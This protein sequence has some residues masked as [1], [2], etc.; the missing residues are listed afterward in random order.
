MSTLA[1]TPLPEQGAKR[2]KLGGSSLVRTTVT[3]ASS[4]LPA[5]VASDA[6]YPV[7]RAT[8]S[9]EN[10]ND[11]PSINPLVRL[12]KCREPFPLDFEEAVRN[13][14]VVEG[15]WLKLSKT[16]DAVTGEY[17]I[18]AWH[19]SMEALKFDAGAPDPL[20]DANGFEYIVLKEPVT[21]A[22]PDIYFA[23]AAVQ[24]KA[25][26][27]LTAEA[28]LSDGQIVFAN[29]LVMIIEYCTPDHS[30]KDAAKIKYV[31]TGAISQTIY[32]KP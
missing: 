30:Y 5:S 29:N 14:R 16:P 31:C 1:Y 13:R 21:P 7:V 19:E 25:T 10:L 15:T 11:D 18:Q 6:K 23:T 8:A 26:V 28:G 9:F 12:Y 2:A 24:D 4:L 27:N 32:Q 3:S 20:T 22:G 17:T